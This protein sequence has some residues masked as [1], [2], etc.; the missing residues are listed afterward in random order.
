[1]GIKDG[2]YRRLSGGKSRGSKSSVPKE[3]VHVPF[4]LMRPMRK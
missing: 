2:I 4:V 3:S 1:M